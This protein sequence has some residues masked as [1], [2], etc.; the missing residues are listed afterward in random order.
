MSLVQGVLV[1]QAAAHKF[2]KHVTGSMARL[3]HLLHSTQRFQFNVADLHTS[4]AKRSSQR[5]IDQ[6]CRWT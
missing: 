3:L 6:L 4:Q 2:G 5:F 1:P